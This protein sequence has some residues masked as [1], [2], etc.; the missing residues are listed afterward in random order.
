MKISTKVLFEDVVRVFGPYF[1]R[2]LPARGIGT[3]IISTSKGLV[4]HQTALDK[5]IGGSIVAYFY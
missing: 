1:R 5:G 3:L 4:T 2:Y